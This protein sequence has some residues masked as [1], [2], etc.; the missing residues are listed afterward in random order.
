MGRNVLDIKVGDRVG[1]GAQVGSCMNCHACKHDNESYC[2]GDGYGYMIDTYNCRWPDGSIAQGGYSTAIRAHKQFVFPIPES[3]ESKHA[4]PMLCAG[5][6]VFS[7]LYR[8]KVG[9]GSRVGIVGIGGL[10]HFGIMFARAMGADA[11]VAISHTAS[12]RD[13]ALKMG[14]TDFVLM[15]EEREWAA[16][17]Q[18]MPLDL[19]LITAASSAVELTAIVS[20]LRV[21]GRLVCLALP[22]GDMQLPLMELCNRGA[23]ISSS[24]IGSKD[25]ALRMLDLA[26]EKR[27][28]PWVEVMDMKECSKAI[29]RLEKGDGAYTM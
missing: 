26:A 24:H 2:V 13:D 1:I 15:K 8:H 3:I 12:K 21:E 5:L 6:T 7:P 4:A 14:A 10:G 22:K 27:I 23:S 16:A 19:I 18:E 25:E 20:C 17:F 9:P 28:I 29:E 11:V